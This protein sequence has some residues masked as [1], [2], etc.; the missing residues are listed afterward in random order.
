MYLRQLRIEWSVVNTGDLS[1]FGRTR[2]LLKVLRHLCLPKPS[3]PCYPTMTHYKPAP[4]MLAVDASM[5][6][7][8]NQSNCQASFNALPRL[9]VT[10]CKKIMC[11]IQDIYLHCCDLHVIIYVILLLYMNIHNRRALICYVYAL[12]ATYQSSILAFIF[13]LCRRR[14]KCMILYYTIV[15][16]CYAHL[17]ILS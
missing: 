5:P 2:I 16:V 4:V 9:E 3:E 11:S 6:F 7:L 14:V 1:P 12:N 10:H 8:V 17:P 13:L 15:Y